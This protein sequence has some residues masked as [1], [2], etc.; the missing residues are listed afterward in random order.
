VPERSIDPRKAI[1]L[2]V[3]RPG[4]AA[5]FA[6]SL[7]RAAM[8]ALGAAAFVVDGRGRILAQNAAGAALL[9]KDHKGTLQSLRSDRGRFRAHPLLCSEAPGCTLYVLRAVAGETGQRAAS[10]AA[11]FGLTRRE[12]QVLQLLAQGLPNKA[13]S[14]ELRAAAKTI[15]Q[16]VTAL[17]SK[18]ACPN[19]AALTALFW[20]L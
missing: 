15:E 6:L 18:S 13:I 12:A 1:R 11:L 19:R 17:L 7:S 16:H 10:A 3:P 8:E 20:T 5:E 9:D 4:H 14:G 2:R